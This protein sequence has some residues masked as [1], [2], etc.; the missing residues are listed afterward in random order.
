M[1]YNAEQYEAFEEDFKKTHHE[2]LNNPLCIFLQKMINEMTEQDLPFVIC[3]LDP[4]TN[5]PKAVHNLCSMSNKRPNG[6]HEYFEETAQTI[7]ER[8]NRFGA[9]F[10]TYFEL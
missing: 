2:E 4:D 6:H 8:L 3:V 9:E 1:R 10:Q 7:I 5:E